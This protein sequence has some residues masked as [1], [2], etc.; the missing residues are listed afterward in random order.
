MSDLHADPLA[1]YQA[2]ASRCERMLDAA[3]RGAWPEVADLQA[4]SDGLIGDLRERAACV[5]LDPMA[6]RRK[7]RILRDILLIDAQIR[8]LADPRQ[9][10]LERLL[11]VA[12]PAADRPEA[13]ADRPR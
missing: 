12:T 11:R 5:R 10:R 1:G 2:L 9:Q 3:R 6:D 8:R 7:F 4:G 13:G